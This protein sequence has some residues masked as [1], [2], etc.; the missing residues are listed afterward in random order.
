MDN[1]FRPHFVLCFVRV[2]LV[3][4]IQ[5]PL[6][7]EHHSISAAAHSAATW[8]PSLRSQTHSWY[9]W[10]T[11]TRHVSETDA[12]TIPL[13]KGP[14]I[15]RGWTN[16]LLVVPRLKFAFCYMEKNACTQFNIL[17]DRL[18]APT[19]WSLEAE[20]GLGMWMNASAEKM[21]INVKDITKANGWKKALFVRDPAER[22]LSAW[23]SKCVE[24][25]GG[26]YENGGDCCLGGEFISVNDTM[27]KQVRSFERVVREVLPK[28]TKVRDGAFAGAYNAH[29]DQQTHF[30]GDAGDVHDMDYVGFISGD[31][32]STH[33]QVRNM[34]LEV[35][36]ASEDDLRNVALDSIFPPG[37]VANHHT[38]S[39]EK[40][41]D[42]YRSED[43]RRIVEAAYPDDVRAI[44]ALRARGLNAA[45]PEVALAALAHVSLLG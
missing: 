31:T 12:D 25:G 20:K 7:I 30:C 29:Y 11:A 2:A 34:L 28:Y 21:G 44:S 3:H 8:Q 14:W 1:L 37:S 19:S 33:S 9:S 45:H 35:A 15:S 36:G 40:I 23:A 5:T 22:F 39:A 13:S 43:V 17:M 38:G 18:N 32:A 4:S 26:G 6:P 24:S 41:N 16:R 10:L 42:F 27:E